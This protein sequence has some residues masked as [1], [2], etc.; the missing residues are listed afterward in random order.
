MEKHK[1]G[2]KGIQC[3]RTRQ[4]HAK[5]PSGRPCLS[6]SAWIGTAFFFLFFFVLMLFP[7]LFRSNERAIFIAFLSH[8]QALEIFYN[9]FIFSILKDKINV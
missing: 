2:S 7:S 6:A 5:A 1:K 4:G 9:S 3:L 8:F